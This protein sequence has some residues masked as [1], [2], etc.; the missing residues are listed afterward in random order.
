MRFRK[1]RIAWSAVCGVACVL[2]IVWWVRSYWRLDIITRISASSSTTIRS[3]AGLI[4]LIQSVFGGPI[5]G[6]GS[7]QHV[8]D[9][10]SWGMQF[11]QFDWA[12]DSRILLIRVPIW[13]AA[14]AAAIL[15]R[16]P[17]IRWSRRFSLRALL[18]ATTL[19]ALVLGMIMAFE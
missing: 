18:I 14:L 4:T 9:N 6:G 19:I 8:F 2:L 5:I 13:V 17:W 11:W 16:A 15:A 10:A 7:W 1:L 3:D 12:W